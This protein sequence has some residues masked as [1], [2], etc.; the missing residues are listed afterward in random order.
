MRF[1]RTRVQEI[2]LFSDAMFTE[3]VKQRRIY[4]LEQV[5]N[6]ERRRDI[7][8]FVTDKEKGSR[9]LPFIIQNDNVR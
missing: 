5:K 1:Q 9:G 3:R 2:V 8:P 4:T 6:A 7:R